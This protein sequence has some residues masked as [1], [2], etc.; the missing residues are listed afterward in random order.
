MRL[1]LESAETW[2]ECLARAGEG[3]VVTNVL[4]MHTQDQVRGD[5]SLAVPTGIRMEGGRLDGKARVVL[6][7]NFFDNLNAAD[8]TAVTFPHHDLPGLAFRSR[9]SP[10]KG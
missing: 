10:D 8:L 2:D 6:N 9:I 1:D 3:V 4:G 5:Y 7:D